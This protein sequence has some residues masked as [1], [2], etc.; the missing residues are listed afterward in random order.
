MY[1]VFFLTYILS[2][3]VWICDTFAY[4]LLYECSNVCKETLNNKGGIDQ[5]Q[6][7]KGHE[8]H[9]SYLIHLFTHIIQGYFTA[10]GQSNDYPIASEAILKN[11][12]KTGWAVMAA[13]HNIA[14]ISQF[15]SHDI[16]WITEQD[17][18]ICV[19]SLTFHG[20]LDSIK[21]N[22]CRDTGGNLTCVGGWLLGGQIVL[23]H[24]Y[25]MPHKPYTGV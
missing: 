25:S 3:V 16:E 24:S 4:I 10:L 19:N 1:N 23:I 21:A 12:G 17:R 18:S 14:P 7:I 6:S 22:G 13:K 2:F 11:I 5:S 15:S 8:L 20:A 9:A